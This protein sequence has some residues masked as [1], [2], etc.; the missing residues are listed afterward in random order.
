MNWL[1]DLRSDVRYATRTLRHAPGFAGVAVVTV[2]L[3]ATVVPARRATRV[4]PMVAL[5]SE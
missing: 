1:D 4:D 3:I 2:A 5:H